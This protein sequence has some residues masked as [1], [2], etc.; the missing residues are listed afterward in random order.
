MEAREREYEFVKRRLPGVICTTC[1]A[2]VDT[3]NDT[4]SAPLSARCQGFE[5]VER[6]K[7]L[8]ITGT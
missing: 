8:F 1:G 6:A 3:Y 5:A 7:Q 2:T 4:C